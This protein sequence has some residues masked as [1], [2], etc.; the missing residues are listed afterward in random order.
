MDSQPEI[1][2]SD[3]ALWQRHGGKLS[4]LPDSAIPIRSVV[5]SKND[6][7]LMREHEWQQKL[8]PVAEAFAALLDMSKADDQA[9][10]SE[11]LQNNARGWYHIRHCERKWPDGASHPL[12]W[13]EWLQYYQEFV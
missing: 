12:I 11:I 13:L 4:F 6:P 7:S 2:V 10:Y 1:T 8:K 5:G 9:R 3:E